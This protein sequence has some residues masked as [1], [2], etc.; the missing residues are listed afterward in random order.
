MPS[1][2]RRRT[3]SWPRLRATA[4][5]PGPRL[6]ATRAPR[7]RSAFGRRGAA[8]LGRWPRRPRDS[9]LGRGIGLS[10]GGKGVSG[11]WRGESM[12]DGRR[13]QG[14]GGRGGREPAAAA[15]SSSFSPSPLPF[16]SGGGFCFSGAR[17]K[18]YA[19]IERQEGRRSRFSRIQSGRAQYCRR[20]PAGVAESFLVF[21]FHST[22]KY[23]DDPN[24]RIGAGLMPMSDFEPQY[25]HSNAV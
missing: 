11:A 12:E 24:S 25:Q 21:P 13:C 18:G 20:A 10:G 1:P 7:H 9:E 2:A 6:L 17:T 4:P 14:R 23:L 16:L 5:R 3:A 22:G 15:P 8:P 19:D